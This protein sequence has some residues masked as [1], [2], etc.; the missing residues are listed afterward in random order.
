MEEIFTCCDDQWRGIGNIKDSGFSLKEDY[1]KYDAI[2][3]FK[4]DKESFKEKGNITSCA[5]SE[6]ILGKK[7]PN[8]CE[9]FGRACTPEHPIGPCMVSSEGSCSIFYKYVGFK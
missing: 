9:L 1:K 2:E 4:I 8:K 5:C 7:S 3:K 6:I